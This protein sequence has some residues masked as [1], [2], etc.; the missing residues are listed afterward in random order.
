LARL[1]DI[2]ITVGVFVCPFM[3]NAEQARSP[4]TAATYPIT[5]MQSSPSAVIDACRSAIKAAEASYKIP[6]GLLMAIGQT[7]SG[8]RDPASGQIQPWPWT[9]NAAGRGRQFDNAAAAIDYVQSSIKEG[10]TSIDTGCLQV[11]LQQHPLAFQ[12]LEDAFDPKANAS[13]AARFLVQLHAQS[14]DWGQAVGD[15]HSKT[16]LLGQTY[17]SAVQVH[18]IGLSISSHPAMMDAKSLARTITLDAL[19]AAWSATMPSAN[20]AADTLE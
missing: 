8:R 15:Y 14:G 1:A 10:I 6:T 4:I 3:V 20:G 18:L 19:R 11:N 12:N 17:R 2:W 5:S 13:Y 16:S 7:E 9:V